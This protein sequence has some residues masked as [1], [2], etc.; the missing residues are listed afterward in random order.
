MCEVISDL[1]ES[2]EF[3]SQKIKHPI[4]LVAEQSPTDMADKVDAHDNN[5]NISDY[6]KSSANRV[7]EKKELVRYWQIRYIMNSVIFFS[8]I[9]YFEGTFSLQVKDGKWPYQASPRRV[10]YALQEL[11][12]E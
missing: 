6:F 9:G 11:L 1:H 5:T 3:D 4:A 10:A 8:G 12:K 7:V 2:S